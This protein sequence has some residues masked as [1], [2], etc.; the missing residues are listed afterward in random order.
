MPAILSFRYVVNDR[1]LARILRLYPG[2]PNQFPTFSRGMFLVAMADVKSI[3]QVANTGANRASLP[4]EG[5]LHS[6][7]LRRHEKLGNCGKSDSRH[8]EPVVITK[9]SGSARV[10]LVSLTR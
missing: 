6:I 1:P 8:L 7:S 5:L 9:E 4:E 3:D 2:R 10:L